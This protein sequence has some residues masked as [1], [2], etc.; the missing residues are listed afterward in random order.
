VQSAL[1]SIRQCDIGI[2]PTIISLYLFITESKSR[3]GTEAERASNYTTVCAFLIF[4]HFWGTRTISQ[5][6]IRICF[7]KSGKLKYGHDFIHH[8]I[9]TG[10]STPTTE[11][12]AKLISLS[13]PL[14]K[15]NSRTVKMRRTKVFLAT[16]CNK[17][18]HQPT[19]GF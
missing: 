3:S 6:D 8:H 17:S 7:P 9:I 10:K 1:N 15:P 5:Y 13:Q 2:A 18:T 4:S 14:Q 12:V 16:I 11:I 19:S